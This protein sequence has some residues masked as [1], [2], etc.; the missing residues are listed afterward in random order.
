[1]S[2][3]D[4]TD[5]EWCKEFDENEGFEILQQTQRNIGIISFDE[6]SEEANIFF[7]SF[8]WQSMAKNNPILFIDI[9]QDI[10]GLIERQRDSAVQIARLS[11]DMDKF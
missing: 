4:M 9:C 6:V 5:E 10:I 11:D 2:K 8:Y 1:M 7:D 3:D